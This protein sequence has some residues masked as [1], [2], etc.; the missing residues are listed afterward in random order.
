MRLCVHCAG[1]CTAIFT[2][3]QE[4]DSDAL[5]LITFVPSVSSTISW[6]HCSIYK[7]SYSTEQHI[8]NGYVPPPRGPSPVLWPTCWIMGSWQEGCGG[9]EGLVGRRVLPSWG[10]CSEALLPSHLQSCSVPGQ[11]TTGHTLNALLFSSSFPAALVSSMV[12]WQTTT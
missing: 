5:C 7:T 6:E 3:V 12:L 4:W 10:L 2:C 1:G 11:V 8:L 9:E